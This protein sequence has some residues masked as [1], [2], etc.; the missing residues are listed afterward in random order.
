MLHILTLYTNILYK[1]RISKR[2]DVFHARH[3]SFSTSAKFSEKLTFAT[4]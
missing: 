2:F 4:P 1:L 3:H